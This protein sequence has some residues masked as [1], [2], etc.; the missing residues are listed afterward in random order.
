M[1]Y[2]FIPMMYTAY[3]HRPSLFNHSCMPNCIAVFEGPML[4][5]RSI[6]DIKPGE[7]VCVWNNCF[8]YRI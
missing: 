1:L 3:M 7:Q 5:I 8:V 2:A 4:R 6:E